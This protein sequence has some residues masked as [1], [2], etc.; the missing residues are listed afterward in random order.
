MCSDN[1]IEVSYKELNPDTLNNLIS[2]FVT[3]TDDN[4]L[5]VS[6][7]LKIRQVK[8]QLQDGTAI[9][10]FDEESESCNIVE[11]R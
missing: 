4:G 11:K 9:I 1:S 7:D 5:D 10:T 2:E 6:L 8:K 3:R